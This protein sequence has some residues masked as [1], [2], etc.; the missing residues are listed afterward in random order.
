MKKIN[1]TLILVFAISL[2]GVAGTYAQYVKT[3]PVRPKTT[4]SKRLSK[5]QVWVPEDWTFDGKNYVYRAGYWGFP[6]ATKAVYKPGRW[7]KSARGYS[8]IPGN[9]VL[10]R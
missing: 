1:K 8:H 3:I 2:F 4:P 10:Q 5:Y 9:W 7:V 6:P